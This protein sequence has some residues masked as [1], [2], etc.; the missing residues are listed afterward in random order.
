MFCVY[1]HMHIYMC[2]YYMYICVYACICTLM[3]HLNT[4]CG[5]LSKINRWKGMEV[6]IKWAL[7]GSVRWTTPLVPGPL[8]TGQHYWL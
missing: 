6:G 4:V 7:G 5:P 3:T 1:G 2:V 8:L